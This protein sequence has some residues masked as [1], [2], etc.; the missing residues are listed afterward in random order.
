VQKKRGRASVASLTL[1]A[2]T[3][4]EIVDRPK[5]PHDLTDEEVEVW[6]SVTSA[7]AAD[8]FD[9]GSLPLLSQ[10]CRHVI[11]SRHVAELIEQATGSPD[12]SIVDYD[13]LLKMQQRESAVLASL[14]TKMRICQTSTINQRGNKKPGSGKKPWES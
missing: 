9:A 4:I 8:W 1:A 7:M 11:R 3:Q 12:L 10:Y 2:P 13:R 5:A 14:A 6:V